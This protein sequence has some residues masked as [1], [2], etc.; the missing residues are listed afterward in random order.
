MG[1]GPGTELGSVQSL[2]LASGAENEEDG[3]GTD[4]VGGAWATAA[5]AVGVDMFGDAD[6]QRVPEV[7]WDAPIV[8]NCGG[9]HDLPS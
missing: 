7:V 4:A 1:G 5:E 9:I 6:F 8:G 3:I 2:P